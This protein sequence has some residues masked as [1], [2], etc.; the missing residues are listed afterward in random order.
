MNRAPGLVPPCDGLL[1]EDVRL[2]S[3]PQ[4]VMKRGEHE[5]RIAIVRVV[6]ERPL[7]VLRQTLDQRAELVVDGDIV[8]G[9]RIVA[10]GT[11]HGPGPL[12]KVAGCCRRQ[13]VAELWNSLFRM[14][15]GFAG[16]GAHS[17]LVAPARQEGPTFTF[18]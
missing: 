8:Q 13:R 18:G 16:E 5:S 2:D 10:V 7:V 3:I 1:D 11:S 17:L 9:F 6:L 12:G 14:A 15:S 4:Q